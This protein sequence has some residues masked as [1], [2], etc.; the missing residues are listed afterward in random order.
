MSKKCEMCGSKFELTKHHY[1]D[2]HLSRNDKNKSK[3]VMI[4]CL[5]CHSQVDFVKNMKCSEKAKLKLY[6]I[7]NKK[8]GI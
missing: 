1:K 3:D 5:T 6:Y 7:R 8:A 2:T 4:L